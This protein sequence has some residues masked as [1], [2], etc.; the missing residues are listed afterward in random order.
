MADGH[1]GGGGGGGPVM[2][3]VIF[4]LGV[5][6]VLLIFWFINGGPQKADLR[7][8][9]LHPPKPI[10]QGGA[11]GPKVGSTTVIIKA[12]TATTSGAHY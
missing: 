3:D 4:V 12:V 9:F 5:L 11:Y 1:G 8:I 7:G 10:D 6:G 2:Q